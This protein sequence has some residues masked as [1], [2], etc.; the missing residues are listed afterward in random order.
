[1]NTLSISHWTLLLYKNDKAL[2][3][4]GNN[5]A[6]LNDLML[7]REVLLLE[8]AKAINYTKRPGILNK[9]EV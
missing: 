1:M 4:A 3:A 6:M 2:E 5:M 9:N 8:L 7:E